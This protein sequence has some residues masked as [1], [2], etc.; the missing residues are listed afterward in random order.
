MAYVSAHYSRL[1]RGHEVDLKVRQALL[2]HAGIRT[3]I[4][5][6]KRIAELFAASDE[7]SSAGMFEA[8]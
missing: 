1:L 7:T 6:A 5:V 2:R 4:N 3:T 8:T